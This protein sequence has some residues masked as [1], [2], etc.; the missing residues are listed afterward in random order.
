MSDGRPTKRTFTAIALLAVAN[1]S[2]TVAFSF[3]APFFPAEVLWDLNFS[4]RST[5]L[6]SPEGFVSVRSGRCL[7]YLPTGHIPNNT[8]HWQ[9]CRF[10][11][12][13]WGL[14]SLCSAHKHRIAPRVRLWDVRN[15]RCY[16]SIRVP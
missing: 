2:S 13:K 14:H 16:A 9:L 4:D 12:S 7:R 10:N 15:Q 1:L 3:I 11:W 5:G 8:D 6:G